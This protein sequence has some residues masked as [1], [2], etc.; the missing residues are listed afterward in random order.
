MRV[1]IIIIIIADCLRKS[2]SCK[3]I[4]SLIKHNSTYINLTWF[5]QMWDYPTRKQVRTNKI[6]SR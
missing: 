1:L 2:Y 6:N 3:C 4:L 5:K